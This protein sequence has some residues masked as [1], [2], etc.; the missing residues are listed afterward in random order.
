LVKSLQS[1]HIYE[2]SFAEGFGRYSSLIL[3]LAKKFL[4]ELN[5]EKSKKD[6][7]E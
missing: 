1:L 3:E 7:K 2:I 6:K 4:A 5:L